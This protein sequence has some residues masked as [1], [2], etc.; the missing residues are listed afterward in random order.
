MK[1]FS[2]YIE[3][4]RPLNGF[5]VGLAVVIGYLISLEEIKSIVLENIL[6]GYITGFFIS[7]SIMIFNDIIDLPI[8]RINRPDRPL[9]SGRITVNRAL[10]LGLTIGILGIIF[11]LLTGFNTLFLAL[12]FWIV[13]ILYNLYL[14]GIPLVGNMVVSLSIAIPFIYGAYITGNN[15]YDLNTYILAITAFT[16][17]T[18]REIIKDIA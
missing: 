18:Y 12:G 14:K 10:L 3:I 13:G 9:P 15:S 2:S 1:T 5:M 11:S 17:N 7:S 4:L 16:I 8:D 6:Y